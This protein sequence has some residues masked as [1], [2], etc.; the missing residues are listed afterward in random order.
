MLTHIVKMP[1]NHESAPE[2]HKPV[3]VTLALTSSIFIGASFILKKKGL[4][5][6]NALGHRAG[7]GH[8]YLKNFMWWAGMI[9]SK[10][11][12]QCIYYSGYR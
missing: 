9:F 4:L 10:F 7:E 2:W 12:N 11:Q 6:T 1:T 3:G 8:A 5:Q